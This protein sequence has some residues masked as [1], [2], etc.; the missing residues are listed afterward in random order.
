MGMKYQKC[1]ENPILKHIRSVSIF[2]LFIF[3]V[4]CMDHFY[5]V[6]KIIFTDFYVVTDYSK[7]CILSVLHTKPSARS[8]KKK[9]RLT[10]CCLM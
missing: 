3:N 10:I 6:L 4:D 8:V 1:I 5:E 9:I 2:I 7:V